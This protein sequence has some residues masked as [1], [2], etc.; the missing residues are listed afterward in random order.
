MN[1]A[2]YQAKRIKIDKSTYGYYIILDNNQKV[3]SDS[4]SY[5]IGKTQ[6]YVFIHHQNLKTTDVFPISRIKQI[7]VLIKK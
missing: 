2:G 6:N 1:L 3:I 5:Y 4:I 7:S